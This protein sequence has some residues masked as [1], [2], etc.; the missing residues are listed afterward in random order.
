MDDDTA[1]A[2]G[3]FTTPRPPSQTDPPSTSENDMPTPGQPTL[4]H[5]SPLLTTGAGVISPTTLPLQRLLPAGPTITGPT[6]S[7]LERLL[8]PSPATLSEQAQQ[9]FP[10]SPGVTID[11]QLD[12]AVVAASAGAR[13]DGTATFEPKNTSS[14]PTT[15]CRSLIPR[16]P[17]INKHRSRCTIKDNE[18]DGVDEG[19]GALDHD[20]ENDKHV[21]ELAMRERSDAQGL[22]GRE[23]RVASVQWIEDV[24][25]DGANASAECSR[26]RKNVRL[27]FTKT[28][29]C[30][31]DDVEL[32]EEISSET[33]STVVGSEEDNDDTTEEDRIGITQSGKQ[34]Y[35][36]R[37]R[38][39][40]TIPSRS[41]AR[42]QTALKPK[43]T[44]GLCP[45]TIENRSASSSALQLRQTLQSGTPSQ[46]SES[47]SSVTG[48]PSQSL[49]NI[50]VW[51]KIIA[52][53]RVVTNWTTHEQQ[54]PKVPLSKSGLHSRTNDSIGASTRILQTSRIPHAP[55][56]HSV[57]G[58]HRFKSPTDAIQSPCSAML[59]RTRSGSIALPVR[60]RPNVNVRPGTTHPV[61]PSLP[62][63]TDKTAPGHEERE[64]QDDQRSPKF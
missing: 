27:D 64:E 30:A 54:T 52:E 59:T 1:P 53:K 2:F 44:L 5:Q 11:Y 3:P 7:Q 39:P 48:A 33:D 13:Q 20:K 21:E 49:S 28:L 8:Q 17:R 58:R 10:L 15:P 25:G 26:Q 35:E 46:S 32:F 63:A 29:E 51:R 19:S 18:N 24:S 43:A 45:N 37:Q 34:F 16:H 22:K 41:A 42:A 57:L 62:R 9:A 12:L 23:K 14:A 31:D 60:G 6:F 36:L 38:L 55:R 50:P 40:C 61:R 47:T 56:P 4:Q